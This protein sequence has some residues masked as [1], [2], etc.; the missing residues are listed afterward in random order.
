M[1][2]LPLL[3]LALIISLPALAAEGGAGAFASG[4]HRNLF[5][6]LLGKSESEV[7]TKLD[8]AWQQ[9]FYGNDENQRVYFP[10]GD[11][12]AYIADIGSSDVRSEGMSYG[13]MIAVQLDHRA[14]FDRLWKWAD[15]NMRHT[16]GPR[17][18][19]FAWQCKFDGTQL[20]PGSASDGEEWFTM[21]LFFAAHRWSDSA[22]AKGLFNYGAEAQ[23]LLKAMRDNRR[24]DDVTAI[25]NLTQKQVVFAPSADASR[26]TDPSYHLP[27][28]YE[29]WARW[30]FL[31]EGRQFWADAMITSRAFF[32]RAAHP[33]TGLMPE[34]A[35]FDGSPFVGKQF[36]AG[37]NDFRYDAWRTFSNVA[38]DHAWFAADPWQ[39][40]QSNRILR[41]LAS[42]KPKISDQFTLEGISRSTDE[43]TGMIAMAAVAGLA[44]DPALA[45]PFVQ[46]FW[47]APIPSGRWRYYNGLLYA[48]GLLEAGG[49]FKIYSPRTP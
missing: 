19:Y 22:A 46:K 40:E 39:V 5:T 1:S 47:D 28:F 45:R 31:P 7:G 23:A 37:K 48:L 36:G 49:H 3:L 30:D 33:V 38:L 14:E 13:M 44:A 8:A 27:A 42:Q 11:D 9:L 16:S 4:H 43:S 34:Y 15:K 20:D 35:N 32:V 18:G 41:F 10:V 24:G 26:L 2:R 17:R 25:F 29:L 21:A 12:L 6:E